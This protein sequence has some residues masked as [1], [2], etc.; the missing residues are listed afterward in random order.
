MKKKKLKCFYEW[1]QESVCCNNVYNINISYVDV[2][3]EEDMDDD[4]LTTETVS[5]EANDSSHSSDSQVGVFQT[6]LKHKHQH[7]SDLKSWF[8]C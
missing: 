6:F 1:K 4:T 8:N 3:Q 2:V 5:P 7:V